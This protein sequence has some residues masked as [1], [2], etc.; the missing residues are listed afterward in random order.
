MNYQSSTIKDCVQRISKGEYAIPAIQRE[1]VWK[2]EQIESLFDSL[3]QGFPISSF[4]FWEVDNDNIDKFKFYKFIKNYHEKK[5]RYNELYEDID[6]D[7]IIAI[8]D[9]QQRLTSLYIA[10][11]GDYTIKQP[12]KDEYLAKELY[13]NLLSGGVQEGSTEEKYEF[14][15][16][17]A[18]EDK[19]YNE[20][21]IKNDK[22]HESIKRYFKVKEI[23]D[24]QKSSQATKIA[25]QFFDEMGDDFE[26]AQD[27]LTDLYNLIHEEKVI[28]FHLEQSDDLNKVLQIFVRINSGGTKLSHSDLLMSIATTD[29]KDRDARREIQSLLTDIK[30]DFGFNI[31]K[32]FVLKC[33]LALSDLDVA[34]RVQNFNKSNMKI[35]EDNW[36]SIKSSI[37]ILFKLLKHIGLDKD[38]ISSYNSLIPIIYYIYKKENPENFVDSVSFEEDR[39]LIYKWI[40]RTTIK[41]TFSGQSDNVLKVVRDCIKEISPLNNFPLKEIV[42]KIKEDFPNKSIYFST[43]EDCKFILDFQYGKSNTY[44]L[45]A[46]LYSGKIPEHIY[47]QDHIFAKNLFSE[48]KLNKLGLSDDEKKLYQAKMNSIG[49]IQL[50]L[51]NKNNAKSD[52]DFEQWLIEKYPDDRERAK[53]LQGQFIPTDE[54]LDFKNFLKVI[55]KREKEILDKFKQLI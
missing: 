25:N 29:W 31:S 33:C 37:N 14:R 10:L 8:L 39:G 4:L 22:E 49:N 48:S 55:D 28:N 26:K 43:N 13:F 12:Y 20:Q 24:L 15:F 2:T 1:F 7:K 52:S 38:K 46:L 30:A 17:T 35:I 9:G 51:S 19:K 21:K 44:L 41:Q 42:E 16:L 36:D 6:K 40:V 27:N 5:H 50:L 11:K 3:M 47:H 34:F 23:F 32:D 45:L 18:D 53:Y 54:S